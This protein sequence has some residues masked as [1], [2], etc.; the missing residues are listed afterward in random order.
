MSDLEQGKIQQINQQDMRE[1]SFIE[2]SEDM[3]GSVTGSMMRRFSCCIRPSI[4]NDEFHAIQ[5]NAIVDAI[6][7]DAANINNV[8][9]YSSKH[10]EDTEVKEALQAQ[11]NRKVFKDLP[12]Y[13]QKLP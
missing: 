11:D 7:V 8:A 3:L 2:V 9:K 5:R 10:L 6:N 13:K 12:F 4:S 1:D